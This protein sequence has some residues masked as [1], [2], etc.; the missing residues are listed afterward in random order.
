MKRTSWKRLTFRLG[1]KSLEGGEMLEGLIDFQRSQ[2]SGKLGKLITFGEM[3]KD[4][5]AMI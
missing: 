1:D 4:Y 3:C 2:N 5:V